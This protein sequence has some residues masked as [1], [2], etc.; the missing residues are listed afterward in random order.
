M[1]EERS[2][3]TNI[4]VPYGYVITIRT[5]FWGRVLIDV[6]PRAEGEKR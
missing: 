1:A 5:T 4:F 3:D 2:C 6:K